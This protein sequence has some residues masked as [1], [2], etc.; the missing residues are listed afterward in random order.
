M[1]M[2]FDRDL[3]PEA[4]SMIDEMFGDSVKVIDER[5]V[6]LDSFEAGRREMTELANIAKQPVVIEINEPGEIKTML[7]GTQYKVTP[8]GW[9]KI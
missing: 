9:V 1:S 4:V 8:Q 6:L 3:N 7:D 2:T 5:N